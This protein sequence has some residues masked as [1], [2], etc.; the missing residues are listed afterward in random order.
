MLFKFNIVSL[1]ETWAENTEEFVNLMPGYTAYP[2]CTHRKSKFGHNSGGIIVFIQN[3]IAK[4]VTRLNKDCDFAVFLKISPDI[5]RNLQKNIIFISVYLPPEGSTFYDNRDPNGVDCLQDKIDDIEAD[6]INSHTFLCGDLN[7]RTGIV[8]DYILCDNFKNVPGMD[9]YIEGSFDMDRHSMDSEINNFGLSLVNLCRTLDVHILNGRFTDDTEGNFTCITPNGASVVDYMIASSDLFEYINKFEV[10]PWTSNSVHLPILAKLSLEMQCP[11]VDVEQFRMRKRLRWNMEIKQTFITR[12]NDETSTQLIQDIILCL[13]EGDIETSIQC[14]EQVIYYGADADVN[15]QTKRK[16]NKI[17]KNKPWWDTDCENSKINNKLKLKIFRKNRSDIN[18]RNFLQSK[19]DYKNLL[20]NKKKN[21]QQA[22]QQELKMNLC[23]PHLF[24]KTVHKLKQQFTEHDTVACITPEM[25]KKYYQELLNKPVVCSEEHQ[26]EVNHFL[27]THDQSCVECENQV[28]NIL[29]ENISII[30]LNDAINKLK[31]NKAPGIDGIVSEYIK[32]AAPILSPVLVM[33]CNKI[34]KLQH[35]PVNWSEAILVSLHKKGSI[36]NTDNYRGI[37]LLNIMSKILTGIMNAR[38]NQ[39]SDDR[40]FHYE[41]QCGFRK[42]RS[43]ID[44]IFTLQGLV[45]KYISKKGG[46]FYCA[47]IDFSKAFD[48]IDHN[49]LWY[50]LISQGIHGN[51]LYLLRDMYD[52]AT[53]CVQTT[54]GLTSN[55][56]C[57]VGTRQGCLLSPFLFIFYLYILVEMLKHVVG[58]Y[59]N[60]HFNNIVSLLFADDLVLCADTVGHLQM[61]LNVLEKFCF[62]WGLKVNLTKTN[63]MV[64]RNGGPLRQNEKYFLNGTEIHA[65]TYYKYLGI[66]FSSRLS[67]SKAKDTLKAQASKAI[68]S[69]RILN[70]KCGNMPVKLQLDMFDKTVLPILLYGAECWGYKYCKEIEDVQVTF[71][72]YVLGVPRHTSNAAVLGELGRLPLNVYYMHKLVKYWVKLLDMDE[73]RLPR[74]VYLMLKEHDSHGRI[75]WVTHVRKLLYRFGF[76]VVWLQQNIG[77]TDT[78]LSLLKQRLTDIACQDWH[79]Q[80]VE[81]DKLKTYNCFKSILE[82]EMYTS[83]D[84]PK[85]ILRS[86]AKLRCSSHNLLIETGRHAGIAQCLRC[87]IYCQQ[88]GLNYLED[89]YH[90]VL[91]CGLYESLRRKYIPSYFVTYPCKEKFIQLMQIENEAVLKNVMLFVYHIFLTRHRYLNMF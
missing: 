7:S 90:V 67:W 5:F 66:L 75:N 27:Q 13:N 18:L 62:N 6:M 20:E 17:T 68:Y 37:S 41:E 47:Y 79:T 89:E 8:E 1:C 72:K 19:H 53:A 45:Q 39:W 2:T 22:M 31:K 33:L 28:P 61:Q 57:T 34:L 30:E 12:L 60:E 40:R 23:D 9:W 83:F 81:N 74:S 82:I 49:L 56:K 91:I 73:D 25:W 3:H 15:Q 46:R 38:L 26:V 24:W 50:R 59:I 11:P 35:F 88:E 76:G 43:T 65:S 87:C 58:V 55:F 42:H 51:F 54:D 71:C 44:H 85:I 78:F 86:L 36:N 14:I 77:N 70:S 48:S 10:L 52:K 64:F 21:H 84:I 4:Q 29:N 69:I 32:L 16:Y 63:I 80:V